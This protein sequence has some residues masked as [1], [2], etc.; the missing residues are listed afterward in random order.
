MSK[1]KLYNSEGKEISSSSLDEK[2]FSEK[3][4]QDLL[5]QAVV[6]QLSNC[7][8][9]TAHTK[10]RS[11]VRGGGKK[12]FK[13]KGTGRARAGTSRSPLWTGGGV[14][15]GPTKN[16][17]FTKKLPK[18]MKQ[19]A[20]KLALITHYK[21]KSLIILDKLNDFTVIKTK[22]AQDF[23]KKYPVKDKSVLIILEQKL[24]NLILSFKN[25]SDIKTLLVNNIN[26]VDILKFDVVF[27]T[28]RVI[29]KIF[30]LQNKQPVSAK[31]K[32]GSKTAKDKK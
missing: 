30:K 24:P 32:N 2:I 26:V 6:R 25:L 7:R 3:V 5:K 20:L 10:T 19:K 14:T 16:R 17:N 23:I 21:N 9:S 27:T 22:T 15:F 29:E 28:K 4:N 1:I 12:P 31:L 18:K 8:T 11:D 13:Q